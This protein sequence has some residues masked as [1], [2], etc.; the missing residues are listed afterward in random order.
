MN[1]KAFLTQDTFEKIAE[2]VQ[3]VLDDKC[4]KVIIEDGIKV[5]KCTNV[6]RIDLRVE[7]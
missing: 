5:Y 7:E 2:A 1:K 4:A 3:D 6:V